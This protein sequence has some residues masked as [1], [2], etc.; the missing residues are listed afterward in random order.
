M[1]VEN[2]RQQNEDDSDENSQEE[3]VVFGEVI[4]KKPKPNPELEAI[5]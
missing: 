5:I 2:L 1:N 3:K 4:K